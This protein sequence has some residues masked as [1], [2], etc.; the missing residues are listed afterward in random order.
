MV[1]S[2]RLAEPLLE[3]K[4]VSSKKARSPEG[5]VTSL[6]VSEYIEVKVTPESASSHPILR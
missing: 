4:R 1:T 5:F 6:C 2:C 3:V